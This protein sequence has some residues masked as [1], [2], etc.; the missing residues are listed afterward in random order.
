M[1]PEELVASAH[2]ARARA[3]APYSNYLV[4]AAVLCADGSVVTGVNVENASYGATICAERVALT[5]AVAQGKRAFVALAVVTEN[6]GSPCGIC[7][8]VMA[9]L[10]PEMA[11]YIG[12]ASGAFRSTT[13]QELL[14]D[15]FTS[16]KLHGEG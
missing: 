4:G 7:R 13:V 5:G 6:G 10:G 14:P 12:D 3:Y 11:V 16:A 1:S 15:S 8:Q 9:E 2:A